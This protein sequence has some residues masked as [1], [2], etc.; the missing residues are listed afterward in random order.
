[1][2]PDRCSFFVTGTSQRKNRVPG[3][4]SPSQQTP[5]PKS[6]I[7][8]TDSGE[9]ADVHDEVRKLVE[10]HRQKKDHTGSFSSGNEG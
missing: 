6:L 5:V 8:L 9:S 10:Y 4:L 1:M 7:F 3:S 2:I